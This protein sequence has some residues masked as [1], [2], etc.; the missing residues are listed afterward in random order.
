MEMTV[1]HRFAAPI[2]EVFAALTE[3]EALTA[4]Y[5]SLGHRDVTI[6]G[7]E[8]SEDGAVTVRSKRTVP[9]DVP[10]FAKKFLSPTNAVE[11]TDQWSAPDAAGARTGTWQVKAAVPVEVSGTLRL[12]PDGDGCRFDIVANVTS[13]VPLVG[14]KLASFVAGDVRKTIDAEF[15]FTERWLTGQRS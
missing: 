13:K 7:R 8:V 12:V 11:Q 3:P 2:A 5:E 6:T 1:S 14:G 9:L 15:A 4:K 10:G